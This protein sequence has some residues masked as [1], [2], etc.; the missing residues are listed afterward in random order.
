VIHC[1][2]VVANWE[3]PI[4]VPN[5]GKSASWPVNFRAFARSAAWTAHCDEGLHGAIKRLPSGEM[6]MA[7]TKKS[8]APTLTEIVDQLNKSLDA[9]EQQ[10]GPDAPA[11]TGDEKKRT[12]RTRKGGER[13]IGYFLRLIPVSIPL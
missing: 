10:L 1:D 13:V 9:I 11:L 5:F 6:T 7:K 4:L 3:F 2:V 8:S 12:A